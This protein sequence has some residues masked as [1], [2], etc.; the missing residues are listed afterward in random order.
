MACCSARRLELRLRR[1]IRGVT[2]HYSAGV[3][4]AEISYIHYV[5]PGVVVNASGDRFVSEGLEYKQALRVFKEQSSTDFYWIC[6]EVSRQ[7]MVPSGNLV[8]P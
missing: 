3:S 5:C 1:W 7:G 4:L 6:D 8:S 2:S